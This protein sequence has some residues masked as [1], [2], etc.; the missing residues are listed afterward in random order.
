MN[1]FRRVGLRFSV[2]VLSSLLA[3]PLLAEGNAGQAALD[4]ATELKLG[5]ENINDLGSVI[6]LCHQAMEA[7]LDKSNAEFARKLLAG[8]LLQRSEIICSEIFDRPMPPSRWPQ[9]RQLALS[10]LE[11]SLQVDAEQP[12]ALYM[13]A[14]L[15]A[16]PGGDREL[17]TKAIESAIKLTEKEPALRAKAL[18]QRASLVTDLEQRRADLDEAVKLAPHSPEVLRGR[19]MFL[20]SRDELD[21][22]VKDFDASIALNPNQPEAHEARGVALFVMKK[23]DEALESFTK[24]IDLVPT[25]PVVYTHRARVYALKGDMQGALEELNR[26]LKFD[27]TFSTALV[28]RARIYQQTHESAKALADVNGVLRSDPGNVQALQLHAVL[29]AGNGKIGQ[30]I[31][32]LEHLRDAAPNDAELLLQLGMF[33]AADQKPEK[34]VE[35]YGQLIER[36]PK[37]W[38]A[39]RGRGDAYLS[40]SKQAEAVADYESAVK[41]DPENSGILNNLAWVLATSP[42]DKLRDG[43]RAIE[44]ATTACKVTDYKEA[45]ILSTLAAGYAET[46]DFETA[47]KWSS[48]AVELGS[49]PVKEQLGKELESYQAGKP[50]REATPP[51]LVSA[52]SDEAASSDKSQAEAP[53]GT[54]SKVR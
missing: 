27:P 52:D 36:D 15:Q 19:G 48:K 44:L 9:L 22:A 46:G 51:G 35:A 47:I 29:L 13:T 40:L 18:L 39:F 23:Y 38:M 30:A 26:A 31:D 33:Y 50:W 21:A 16:L 43:R 5:A 45:H 24:A 34:A 17:A 53:S 7:G 10:D 6:R 1:C 20:L 41:I 54:P 25:S 37:N 11:E 28:L 4:E 3:A 42:D 8:T 2:C 14:K 32:D 49:G 12:E